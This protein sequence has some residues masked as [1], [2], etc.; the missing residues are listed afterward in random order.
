MVPTSDILGA[1]E[2]NEGDEATVAWRVV[3]K[4]RKIQ[5][6]WYKAKILK[7][8]GEFY[9]ILYFRYSLDNLHKGV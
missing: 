8:S 9:F 1:D 5:T 2:V 7:Y 3:G 4:N 6:S